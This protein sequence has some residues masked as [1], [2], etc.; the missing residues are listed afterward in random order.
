MKLVTGYLQQLGFSSFLNLLGEAIL[1]FEI[2][3]TEAELAWLSCQ[4]LPSEY[5]PGYLVAGSRV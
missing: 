5:G 1:N 3:L 4:L 2:F